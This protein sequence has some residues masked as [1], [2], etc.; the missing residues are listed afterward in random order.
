MGLSP[1][2][3]PSPA[4]APHSGLSRPEVLGEALGQRKDLSYYPRWFLFHSWCLPPVTPISQFSLCSPH[5]F[6]EPPLLPV[7][8]LPLTSVPCFLRLPTILTSPRMHPHLFQPEPCVISFL[9]PCPHLTCPHRAP[10]LTADTRK[11]A[12]TPI[13]HPQPPL[14][15]PISFSNRISSSLNSSSLPLS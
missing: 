9:E 7:L 4:F 1:P 15:I 3:S 2:N 8:L 10:V 6:K 13:P 5:P 12:F 14:S 11:H